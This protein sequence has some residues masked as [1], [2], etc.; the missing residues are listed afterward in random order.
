[1]ADQ[2]IGLPY[3]HIVTNWSMG[4]P[5]REGDRIIVDMDATVMSSSDYISCVVTVGDVWDKRVERMKNG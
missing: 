1:M 5:R 4:E 2:I 3:D